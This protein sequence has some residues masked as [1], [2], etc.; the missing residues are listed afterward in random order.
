FW[1]KTGKKISIQGT[2]MAGFD[3]S[4]VECFNCHKMGH[5]AREYRAPRSQDRGRRDNYKQWSKDHALVADEEAPTEFT[6]MAKTSAECED[7]SWTGILEF[8]DDTVTDYSRPL[9]AIESTSDEAQNRNPFVPETEASPSTITSKPFI[10]F[11]KATDTP[12]VVKSDKVKTAK[13][14]T[15]NGC[16]RHMTG[17]IS[18]LSD[19]EPFDGGYVSFG[20]GGCKIAG[21]RTIITGK[22]EFENVY[23]VKDLKTPRQHNMYSIDLNNIVPHKDLTC[24]V[25]KASADEYNLEKFDA[26]GDEGYFIGYSTSSKSFKVFNK[27]TK[28]VEENLHVDFLENKAIEKGAGPNWLFD[29]DSLTKSMNYVLVV[30]AVETLIP[31]V[32]SP[33]PTACFTDSQEPSSDTRLISKRVANQVETPSLDNILTLTNRFEDILGV[34][35]NSVDSNGMEADLSNMETTI[36]A[37]PTPTLRIHKDHPKSQILGPVDTPIQTRH[38]SKEDPKFLARMYKVE[39]AMYGL[40]QAPRAWYVKRIFRYI[41]GHPKLGLW[42]PKESPFDLVA[43][44]NSDYGGATQDRKSTTGGCQFLGRRLISWQCKKQII[45]VTSTTK[46]EYVAAAN[47]ILSEI[48]LKKLI[49][50]DHIHTDENVADLL[51]KP[52]DTGRFQ[53]LVCLSPKS[54]RFNEFSSNIATALVCLA[55][56]RVYNFSIFDGMGEGSGTPTESHHTPTSE[57]SQSSQHE[58]PSPSLPPVTIAT[59]PIVIPTSPLLTVIPTDTTLLR[60][61]TRRAR[62]AQS[63]ALPPVADEPASPIEDDSQGEACLTDSGLAADQDR[64]NIAKTSTLPSDSTPRVTS[65]ANDE[66]SMQQKL[67]ELTALCTSLQRQQSEMVSRFEAQELEINSLKARINLLEDKDRGVI[68]Q[69]GDDALIKGRRLDEREEAA[70]RVSDDTEEMATVLT[71]MDASSILTSRGVQVVPTAAEVTTITV[72]IP[73]GSGVVFTASPTIPTSAPIFTTATEKGLGLEQESVKKLKKSEE[74]KETEEVPEEKV[75]EMMQLVHVEEI[76]VEALQVKH[77]IIDW[78]VH[79]EGRRS[80]WKIIRLGGSSAGYQFFMDILKHLDREDLNQLWELVKE[81]LSIRPATSDKEME[82]SLYD[83]CGVHHVTSKDKE[84]FMLVEKDYPFRKGLAIIMMSYKLQVENYSQMA[85]DLIMKI[86]KIASIPIA[87]EDFPLPEQLPTANEE[88]FPLLIQSD[89]TAEELYAATEPLQQREYKEKRV[90][91]S[92]CSRHMIGNK[93]YLTDYEDYDGGFISFGDGKGTKDNIVA[94]QAEKK[95]EPEQEYILIPIRTTDPLISQ[96]PKDSV[97]DAGKKATEVDKSQVS[98]NSGQDDQVTRSEFEGLLQQ[99]RQ[100]EHINSTNSFNTVSSLVNNAGPSF[101][102]AALP[103]PINAAGTLATME[104]EVDMNN[105]VS[106]YTILDASLTKFLKDHPKDQVFRN[107]K[108]ERGIVIKNKA[109]LVAQGHTQEEGIDYDEVFAPVARIE[110]IRIFLAYA[111]FKDFVVYQMNVK[112]AFLYG[113]IEEETA[114]TPME[115][116]KALVKDAET[117]DVD[118]HLYRSMIGSLMYLT[119]F[120]PNITFAVCA[121]TRFQVTPNTSHLYD[122]KR[123]FRYL[124]E[125]PSE[126]KG[127]E[128]IIDFLNA[129]PIRYALMVNPTVYDSRVKQF[130]TTTKVKKV[131]DLK[132]A[133]IAQAKEIAKLKKRVKKLEKRKKSRPAGLKRLNKVVSSKQVESSEEK[134]SLGAQEDAS[135]QGRSI[136][137]LDQDAE[138]ALVDEAQGRMHDANMFGVDDLEERSIA[139]DEEV[140]RKLEAEMRAEIEKEERIAREKDKANR[141]VIEE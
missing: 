138:I 70:K 92:G 3:K 83:T 129:K 86:Y 44:S 31:T 105:V 79:I 56:N 114:S 119:A 84:I 123:I 117:E 24:L 124:K 8:V 75:K 95:K 7:M 1:K 69:S 141:A 81:T 62:I 11:V 57:A 41:K 101:V 19:Y 126:S 102:N 63:L 65:F 38:K 98:D 80:Y 115:P 39:K 2:D 25:A 52:F 111:S 66:G 87:S 133:K 85:N 55:T 36:I 35:T 28:R 67:G 53:Y 42:Y 49:S 59:I 33:V 132:E 125:K 6:L 34:T 58:L 110:A 46:A 121:C 32:S 122:V 96:G 9:P 90:T 23:F 91:D 120:R 94:G 27:R 77:P 88:K 14:P 112:S 64:A 40:H 106:S 54:T 134:D 127:F 113:K 72:S 16:S 13:K 139:L 48:V 130:W 97:V 20:Q 10:K 78:K 26:K 18:Y 103:S 131:F 51:T 5:F 116:N 135:K 15:V 108:D 60:H 4:K 128:Q 107:K 74:V 140:A 100:I 45:M 137:D 68:E 118:V 12:T 76:Y 61:Y 30:V 93:C 71:S 73:T 21:K 29:I 22:L 82:I 99:E 37:S 89:A 43:Y 47:I 104:E 50:V 109:R 136:E 17:N